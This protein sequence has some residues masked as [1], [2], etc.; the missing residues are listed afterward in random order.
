MFHKTEC[1]D[2]EFRLFWRLWI[3]SGA[4]FNPWTLLEQPGDVPA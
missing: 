3:S 4:V 1:S 2:A